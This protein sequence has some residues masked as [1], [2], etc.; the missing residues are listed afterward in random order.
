MYITENS[1][2]LEVKVFNGLHKQY[3]R[4]MIEF[5]MYIIHCVLNHMD[6]YKRKEIDWLPIKVLTS[7][8]KKKTSG[9]WVTNFE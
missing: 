6:S 1:N 3:L 5:Y 2:G 8:D 9:H 4:I 7:Q